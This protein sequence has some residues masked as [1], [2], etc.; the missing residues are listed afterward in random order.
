MSGS[1]EK[2][3]LA[4]I[5]AGGRGT[6]VILSMQKCLPVVEVKYIC[7]VD[8][9]RGGRAISELEKQQKVKPQRV[10]DMRHV[11][12][13]KDVDAVVIATPEHLAC[14]G[15]GLGLPGR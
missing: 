4:L 13:D 6:Q 10:E 2:V 1:N 5:G 9:E 7:D 14:T 3:V 15:N 8:K 12:D 11:F